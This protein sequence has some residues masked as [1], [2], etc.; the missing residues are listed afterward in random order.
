MLPPA[1]VNYN[2]DLLE[3]NP[4][5]FKFTLIK[6]ELCESRGSEAVLGR[7]KD[8]REGR[9]EFNVSALRKCAWV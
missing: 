3:S 6:L 1:L 5:I 4:G 9:K 7:K 8:V 2:S